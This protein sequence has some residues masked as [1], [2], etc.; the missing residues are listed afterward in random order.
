MADIGVSSGSDY[1]E[2]MFCEYCH[3]KEQKYVTAE[4]FCVNCVKYFC[5]TCLGYHN[6]FLPDH[7]Q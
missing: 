4:G 7:I 1:T 6:K 2:E 5:T 3:E